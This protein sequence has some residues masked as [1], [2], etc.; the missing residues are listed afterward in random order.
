MS[1]PQIR[2][3]NVETN[4]V[5]DREMTEQEYAEHLASIEEDNLRKAEKAVAQAQKQAI[6]DRLGLT[7]E[8]LRIVLG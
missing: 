1:R 8:E 3:H 4:Q 2:I 6:L 5:I 7:D